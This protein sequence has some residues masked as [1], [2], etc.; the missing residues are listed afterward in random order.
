MPIL[1]HTFISQFL[2]IMIFCTIAFVAILLIL[3]LDEIAHFIALGAPIP[4][5]FRFTL[6]QIPYIL[7]IAIPMSCLIA[8]YIFM[9]NLSSTH[10][11]TAL[12]ASGISIKNIIYPILLTAS[13][14]GLLNLWIVSEVATQSHLTNNQLKN[15]L[16]AINPLLIMSNKHFMRLK[17]IYFEASGSSKAGESAN[18]AF[19]AVPHKNEGRI[20]LLI[21]EELKASPEHFFT[22]QSTLIFPLK[23]SKDNQGFDQLFVENTGKSYTAIQDFSPLLKE[24]ISLINNDY[25]K[26]SL[27]I[28]R[29]HEY[30]KAIDEAKAI[31]DI[32]KIKEL[33]IGLGKSLSD[34]ARRLSMA[35][36]VIGFTL[37]GLSFGIQ[38]GRQHKK[39]NLFWVIGLTVLYLVCFF[40]AKG[41]GRNWP[42]ATILYLAPT[43][44]LIILPFFIF[45]RISRGI[46]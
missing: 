37:I 17:G 25:L 30:R 13:L 23:V 39:S 2:K 41:L 35:F 7:P 5:V 44:L 10:E 16:R 21:A 12:R 8:A 3:R 31:E 34:I 4:A 46:E 28:I 1:W 19:L 36:C 29:I 11:L 42:L 15:Q 43:L 6:Y 40:T 38:I 22:N 32:A 24:K 33:R 18:K 9:Q 26:M 14:I 20:S 45:N 27:L